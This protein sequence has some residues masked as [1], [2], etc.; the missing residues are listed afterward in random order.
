M[1]KQ[2]ND[3]GLLSLISESD[4]RL[5]RWE[6]GY[7]YALGVDP[8]NRIDFV[9]ARIHVQSEVTSS[10]HGMDRWKLRWMPEEH[11]WHDADRSAPVYRCDRADVIRSSEWLER[12]K[13]ATAI[14]RQAELQ[15]FRG[16][17]VTQRNGDGEVCVIPLFERFPELASW[18]ER[19]SREERWFRDWSVSSAGGYP[20]GR[21]WYLETFDYVDEDAQNIGF[22]PQFVIAPR[23]HVSAKSCNADELM[24]RLQKFDAAVKVPFGW[25]FYMVHGNRITADVGHAIAKGVRLGQVGL[26]INDQAVLMD[27]DEEPYGF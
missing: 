1:H 13:A 15:R 12:C 18:G 19:K 27:W 22:I 3:E 24:N 8:R 23:Q 21:H 7:L 20:M 6:G 26:P 16:R 9:Q 2:A 5:H 10:L 25:F 11:N 4:L 17:V 14:L